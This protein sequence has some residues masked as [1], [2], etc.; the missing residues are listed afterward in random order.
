MHALTSGNDFVNIDIRVVVSDADDHA[1]YRT[2][3][4]FSIVGFYGRLIV[5]LL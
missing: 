4:H 5:R 1:R 3:T 2:R